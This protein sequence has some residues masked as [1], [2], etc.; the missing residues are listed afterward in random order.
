MGRT[1]TG[2]CARIAFACLFALIGADPTAANPA[3]GEPPGLTAESAAGQLAAIES[4]A[5]V[6]SL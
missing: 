5:R 4:R 3:A 1:T 6:Q 2:R